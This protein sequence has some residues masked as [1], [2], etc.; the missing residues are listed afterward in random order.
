[1][2]LFAASF[3]LAVAGNVLYHVSQKSIPAGAPPLLSLLVTYGVA[4][5]GTALLVPLFPSD[6]NLVLGIRRLN[7]ASAGVGIAII[8]VELGVLLAYRSGWKLSVGSVAISAAVALALLPTGVILFRER[9]SPVQLAGL[10]LCLAG[11][12]LVSRR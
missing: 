11:L 7:W 6:R 1:M 4:L 5:A 12:I 10:G 9:P 8:A 2:N 3:A